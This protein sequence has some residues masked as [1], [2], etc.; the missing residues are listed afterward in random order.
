MAEA[1]VGGLLSKGI[2]PS[3]SIHIADHVPSRRKIFED[4]GCTTQGRSLEAISDAD[5]VVLSV[6]PQNC[7][8]VFGELHG[9]LNPDTLVLSI[10]A[11]VTL[12]RL[13]EGLGAANVVRAMPNTPSK[14][15]QGMTVWTP[16]QEVSESQ[17]GQ[18]RMFLQ[19]V[20]SEISVQEEKFLDMA[21]AISGTGPMYFFLLM[22]SLI[23]SG[24][25]M[26]FPRD[27][28]T[29]LV[30]KTA[31]GSA[32]YA[33]QSQEHPTRLR[34]DI[35]SPGGTTAAALYEADKTGFRT[36]VHD[37]TWAAYRRS[38]ELGGEDSNVGPGRWSGRT[39]GND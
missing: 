11:G 13:S 24:V 26:G 7:N 2:Q 15:E 21:T 33:I 28:A 23:D 31:L 34:N 37:M 3:C 6:K 16:T 35:T 25:H 29:Q 17:L 36:A 1:F 10:C 9:K 8:S 5:V 14:I 38:L 19:A 20:G 18:A 30:H 32:L 4:L 27:I 12:E 22:E 39:N